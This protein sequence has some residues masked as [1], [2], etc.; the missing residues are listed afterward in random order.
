MRRHPSIE[1]RVPGKTPTSKETFWDTP[2]EREKCHVLGPSLKFIDFVFQNTLLWKGGGLGQLRGINT[3]HVDILRLLHIYSLLL[4]E[5]SKQNANNR[6][7]VLGMYNV[8]TI[9]KPAKIQ[10]N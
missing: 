7:R 9:E 3:D 5:K 6:K 10:T 2:G 8:F 1:F 4:R